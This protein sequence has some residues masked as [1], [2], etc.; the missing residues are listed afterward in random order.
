[1]PVGLDAVL[2]GCFSS[3][4]IRLGSFLSATLAYHTD[5]STCSSLDRRRGPSRATPKLTPSSKISSSARLYR[6]MQH[7]QEQSTREE[8]KS[9]RTESLAF[10]LSPR[11]EDVTSHICRY[12]PCLDLV[13]LRV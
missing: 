12:N 8:V 9:K 7:G 11:D 4:G 10:Q 3:S 6:H 1:M 13:E 2:H 5:V